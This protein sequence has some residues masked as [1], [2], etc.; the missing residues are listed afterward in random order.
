MPGEAAPQDRGSGRDRLVDAAE[1]LVALKGEAGAA[2]RAIIAEAGQRHNSAITYHFGT[3]RALLDAVWQVRSAAVDR[4]R[5]PMLEE[6]AA[7]GLEELVRAYVEPLARYLDDTT[8]SYWARFNEHFLRRYPL[9]L[10]GRL[11]EKL[12]EAP[13]GTGLLTLL[14]VLEGLQKLTCDGVEPDAGLRVTQAVRTVVTTFA[15]WERERDAGTVTLSARDLSAQ[16]VPGVLGLLTA[17]R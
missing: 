16:L 15:A 14:D 8:P 17:P 3:R 12:A 2:N 5:R 4:Y 11:R 1:K 9:Q 10:P 6:L 13:P 7:P